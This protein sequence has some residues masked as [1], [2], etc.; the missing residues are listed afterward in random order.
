[1]RVA[2]AVRC[3][4]LDGHLPALTGT[5]GLRLALQLSRKFGRLQAVVVLHLRRY[6][7]SRACAETSKT[8]VPAK[9]DLRW[10]ANA[11]TIQAGR[12]DIEAKPQAVFTKLRHGSDLANNQEVFAFKRG[13]NRGFLKNPSPQSREAKGQEGGE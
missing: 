11:L 3:L 2:V 4:E 6:S 1:M 10:Q 9:V 13:A 7:F 5:Q 8:R 12:F